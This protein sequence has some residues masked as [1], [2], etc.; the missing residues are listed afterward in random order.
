V[1]A[2]AE[3]GKRGGEGSRIGGVGVGI[4]AGQGGNIIEGSRRG[5]VRGSC[6]GLRPGVRVAPRQIW[7]GGKGATRGRVWKEGKCGWERGWGLRT[8]A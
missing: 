5:S 6:G 2:G 4:V 7:T 1:E 8:Y 3:G